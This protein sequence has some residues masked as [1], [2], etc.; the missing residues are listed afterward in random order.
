MARLNRMT[1]AQM[2]AAALHL[3]ELHFKNY[4]Y[5]VADDERRARILA[6]APTEE[7]CARLRPIVAMLAAVGVP[8]FAVLP[9]G[10]GLTRGAGVALTDSL[11]FDVIAC[12]NDGRT[13]ATAGAAWPGA[14]YYDARDIEPT[15]AGV[16]EAI[17][18][19]DS[20]KREAPGA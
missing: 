1:P 6:D 20:F 5:E 17:D 18:W 16:F 3:R 7:A 12:L 11:G 2:A 19:I 13:I 14:A 4:G 8:V 15:L 10:S 9:Y